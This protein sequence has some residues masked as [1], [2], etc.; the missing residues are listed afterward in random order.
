MAPAE[1]NSLSPDGAEKPGA[2]A[3]PP[4]RPPVR[5]RPNPEHVIAYRTSMPLFGQRY[6]LAVFSGH[7]QRRPDRIEA[8]GQRR[9]W[10]YTIVSLL[11]VV[12]GISTVVMCTIASA[13]L[14][15][16]MLGIDLFE[17]HFFLH[18]TFCA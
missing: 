9:P 2:P 5:E 6:Y 3:V 4:G 1:L 17:D 11:A 13:Y 15:K 7:E 12:G 10:G 18:R 16:S 8:E 14:V